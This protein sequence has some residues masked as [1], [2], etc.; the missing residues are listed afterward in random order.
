MLHLKVPQ[1]LKM[2]KCIFALSLGPSGPGNIK[3]KDHNSKSL[4]IREIG[5]TVEGT[6]E[7]SCLIHR[8]KSCLFMADL[9]SLI[10]T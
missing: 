10:F 2:S 7:Y 4:K 3:I 5:K 1:V 9:G 6:K 8:S